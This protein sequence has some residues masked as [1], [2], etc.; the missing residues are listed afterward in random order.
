MAI[1]RSLTID[2]ESNHAFT[3]TNNSGFGEIGKSRQPCTFLQVFCD[4]VRRT[5]TQ[6]ELELGEA[7]R[8]PLC[9]LVDSIARVC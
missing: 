8:A 7:S 9:L 6:V 4:Q 1:Y 2:S 3:V 5:I